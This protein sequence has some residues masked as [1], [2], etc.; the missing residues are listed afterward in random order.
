MSDA[1]RGHGSVYKLNLI[2]DSLTYDYREFF[3][4]TFLGFENM[5]SC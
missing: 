3:P 5:T 2:V 4:R 1:S